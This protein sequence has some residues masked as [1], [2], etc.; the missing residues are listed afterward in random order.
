MMR[1]AL[2]HHLEVIHVFVWLILDLVTPHLHAQVKQL[3]I[4]VQISFKK[5]IKFA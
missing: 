3:K 2:T 4:C 1:H 5:S